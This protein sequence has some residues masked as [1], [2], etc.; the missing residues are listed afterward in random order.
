MVLSYVDM[1][2]VIHPQKAIKLWIYKKTDPPISHYNLTTFYV[3]VNRKKYSGRS[4]LDEIV[5]YDGITYF[6]ICS[7][8]LGAGHA[9]SECKCEP[10]HVYMSNSKDREGQPN[11]RYSC[12]FSDDKADFITYIA[13]ERGE[14]FH[15]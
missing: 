5:G 14:S 4:A 13:E 15:K 11:S 10:N 7:F 12:L 6:T 3:F 8:F 9:K 1:I 2:H